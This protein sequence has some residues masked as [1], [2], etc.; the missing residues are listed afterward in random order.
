M[1]C[2]DPGGAANATITITHKNNCSNCHTTVPNLRPGVPA[3]G[4]DCT[5][6]HG[7]D[8][9]EQHTHTHTITASTG[10]V[11]CHSDSDIVGV[12]HF[13]NPAN[14]CATCHSSTDP[15]VTG[16]IAAGVAECTTCHTDSWDTIH[17]GHAHTIEVGPNDLS[18]D[19]PGTFCSACHVVANWSEIEGVEHN[20]ATNGA[21]SCAT[22]HNSPR[23][24]VIDAINLGADPT[25]CLDCHSNKLL[26]VHGNI[27]HVALGYVT[28]GSTSC[29]NCHDPG[30]ATNA[31]VSVTHN[32][33][34]SLCHT[35][36]PNLQTGIPA[37][38][39][40]CT[41]CHTDTWTVLH[42][43]PTAQ[44]DHSAAVAGSSECTSC[45]DA[46]AGTATG[47]P[48]SL[49]DNKVHDN[50][51]ACHNSDGSLNS[52]ASAGSDGVA[53][54]ADC[55]GSDWGA[56][57]TTAPD[58]SGI[59]TTSGTDNCA[60][61]H[62]DALFDATTHND[63]AQCHDST[64]GA[65][66]SIAS[67]KSAPGNCQTCHTD[68]WTALHT[69]PTAQPDHSAAVS[70]SSEC[71][72]CHDATAGTATGVP[73]SLADNKV[74]D[75]CAVCH[76]ADG[77]LKAAASA[78][79]DGVANCTDCHTN[80][81][82]VIHAAHAHTVAVG[83]NDLSYNPPGTLCS[84]CHVVANWSEIEGIEHNVATNGAGSCATCHNS[85]RQEVIDAIALGAN[86]THCL[87]C[88][89][90]KELTPHGSVDHMALGYVTITTPCSDCHDPS[91]VA[92]A[93]VDVTHLG[94]CSLC[95][96]TVPDLQPGLPSGG[97]NCAACH[98]SNVQTVHPSCTTCHGEPPNGTTS[99][100]TE[101]A[102]DAH[103]PLGFGS[104]IPS[105]S[106]CHDG[107]THYSG[108]VDVD[109][110]ASFDAQSGAAVANGDGTCSSTRCHG[111]QT[112]PAWLIGSID[113]NTDC[114]SCHK[115]QTWGSPD[116]Y[117][118]ND[119]YSGRHRDHTSRSSINCWDCHNTTKL[120]T[121]HFSNLQTSTFEQ[122]PAGTIGGSGT[123]VGSYSNGSCSNIQCHGS[124][125]W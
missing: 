52:G 97:G 14:D 42:T 7:V 54:C 115:R 69:A 11:D 36:V 89:S 116:Q 71:T 23:Q 40:D 5:T 19:P 27:D 61:C 29:A 1:N 93:T 102:H 56:L 15:N 86:P 77:S 48:T 39:G 37:G 98:G 117:K 43:S 13:S 70:G 108:T 64:S 125:Q 28:I 51:A 111:G 107:A 68:T 95:H 85:T 60:S 82:D 32:G 38:G 30:T 24:E 80:T 16:A 109:I 79:N 46:T 58:H 26:T 100:N 8:K 96:T 119:Y 124:E 101:G 3:G 103:A 59:V 99:P 92:N 88:H 33:N 21:G 63:C 90:D 20:V 110:L 67:G 18:Y 120:A 72:S 104:V 45:H 87:D 10:C 113:V 84:S 123:K 91:G 50:C 6:C 106:A 75:N 81:F 41:T 57:H 122:D 17:V 44:P 78:G 35:T 9:F 47:I 53:N 12:I 34:C 65:L 118:Y 62:A 112:S 83:S 55:H 31:T 114:G 22:C 49:A 66:I 74:H 94:N 121:G 4:G 73:T 25:N 76:N 2:H 105:C